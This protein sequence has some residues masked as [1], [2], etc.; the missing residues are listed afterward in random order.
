MDIESKKAV[1]D[2]KAMENEEQKK[3]DGRTDAGRGSGAGQEPSEEMLL[4]GNQVPVYSYVNPSLHSFCLCLYIRAG[5]LF[6]T[7]KNNGIS[8]FFEHITFKNINKRHQGNLYRI[9]DERGLYFNGETFEEVVRFIISGASEH[10]EEAADILTEV[11]APLEVTEEDIDTERMRIKSE[12][13]EDD[14]FHTL[15]YFSRQIVWRK[16]PLKRSIIG[17][18]K[19]LNRIGK[20]ELQQAA[21]TLLCAENLFFYATGNCTGEQLNYLAQKIESFPVN[22][23]EVPRKNLAPLPKHFFQRNCRVACQE[24]SY[25][26]IRFSFDVDTS[27]Y[28]EAECSLLYDILCSGAGCKLHQELSE[29]KG[30]I[31]SYSS[32]FERYSNL[33]TLSF[34]YEVRYPCLYASIREVIRVCRQM[35]W[36]LTDELDSVLPQYVDNGEILLDDAEDYNWVFAFEGHIR[37][38][39]T[40][41]NVAERKAQYEA[42]TLERIMEIARE[43]FQTSNLVVTLKTGKKGVD[44]KKIRKICKKLDQPAKKPTNGKSGE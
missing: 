23:A 40:Y 7:G 32:N 2:S 44:R 15:D 24:S 28:T 36:K 1:R 6:E 3:A 42:V 27:R 37:E 25:Y 13:R 17:P 12:L 22:R 10:F 38:R 31:Y 9:L 43:I 20:K 4:T 8:H 16:T 11:F 30:Y 33:G 29:K 18:V 39:G 41:R 19:N 26:R 21:K 14:D 34:D 5:S 35:K